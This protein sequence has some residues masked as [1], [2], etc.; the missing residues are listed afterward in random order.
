MD[1]NNYIYLEPLIL[2]PG[3][4]ELMKTMLEGF[5]R[6]LIDAFVL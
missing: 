1:N 3:H 5:K 2:W 6:D 4:E